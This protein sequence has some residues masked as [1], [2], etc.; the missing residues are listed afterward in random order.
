[1]KPKSII[2]I[3]IHT[4]GLKYVRYTENGKQKTIY[5]HTN[6][7]CLQKY[8]LLKKRV[9]KP[10]KSSYTFLS[11]YEKWL[12]VYKSNLKQNTLEAIKGIY[13]KYILPSIANKPL[14]Q[15]NSEHIQKI[16]NNVS[17][18]PRQQTVVYVQLNSCLNQAYKLN[19]ITHNPCLACVIKK[20]KGRKGQALT[21]E[22]QKQLFE[23]MENNPNEIN[24]LIKIYINTGMRNSELLNIQQ[25]DINRD[26]NEIYINGT[27][28][29]TSKRVLQTTRQIIELIPKDPL[30]PFK[31]WNKDRLDKEFKKIT[32]KLKFKK[33]TIHSL[34]HTFA[35]NCIENGIDMV[36]LQKWLGH[37][38]ITMTLDRY[39]H[40]SEEYKQSQTK[41][42][43]QIT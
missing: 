35:T 7:E 32:T 13:N 28:T 41:K 36:V 4:C 17:V 9:N 33:I 20:E 43:K 10:V 34:R 2:K 23:Y 5:G 21:K 22:Q 24:T 1:M 14:K 12:Q 42:I 27:K 8:G 29:A 30:K 40:I 26:K 38:S 15:V 31:S 19:L 11:W 39:T 25:Q 18:Y 37:S 3:H 6:Q 16:I